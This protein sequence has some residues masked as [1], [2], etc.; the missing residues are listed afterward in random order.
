MELNLV[1]AEYEKYKEKRKKDNKLYYQRHREQVLLKAKEKY[2]TCD[3]KK[4]YVPIMV[5][6]DVCQCPI[7]KASYRRHCFS[8]NHRALVEKAKEQIEQNE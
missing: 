5:T 3:D 8:K 1:D 2:Q 7:A 6:C 4:Q